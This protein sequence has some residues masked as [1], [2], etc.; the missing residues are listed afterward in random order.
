M[1]SPSLQQQPGSSPAD[2]RLL[3]QQRCQPGG[4]QPQNKRAGHTLRGAQLCGMK[5]VILLRR[6][7]EEQRWDS[8]HYT[9]V[10]LTLSMLSGNHHSPLLRHHAEK[11]HQF[12]TD[13]SPTP[14]LTQPQ[15]ERPKGLLVSPG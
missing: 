14:T 13:P 3:G 11:D 6:S 5:P 7:E 8:K 4:E 12:W 1:L 10:V 2:L 15:G 9:W